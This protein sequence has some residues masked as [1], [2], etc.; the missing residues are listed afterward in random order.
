MMTKERFAETGFKMSYEE[1]QKCCCSECRRENCV[2]REAYRRLPEIDGGLGLCP[3]LK[4]DFKLRIYK[5]SGADKGN[6]D[7]EEFFSTREEIEARYNEL[8]MYENYSLNPTAWENVDG[9][10]KRLEGF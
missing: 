8:F 7:H 5:L 4:C 9:E 6:I 1:Y 3:N 2:H 10:W